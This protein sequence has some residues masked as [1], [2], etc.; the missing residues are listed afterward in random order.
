[1]GGDGV[2]PVGSTDRCGGDPRAGVHNPLA[3]QCIRLGFGRDDAYGRYQSHG[4]GAVSKV[5]G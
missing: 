2:P 5:A 1:M 4:V 3:Y